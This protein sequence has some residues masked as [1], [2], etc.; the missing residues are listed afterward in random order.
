[1]S[2][3]TESSLM[4]ASSEHLVQAVGLAL[5]LGDLGLSV[6]GEVSKLADLM[7]RHEARA[8]EARLQQVAQPRRVGQIGLSARHLLDVA[9]VHQKRLELVLE[10]RPHR[11]PVDPGGLHRHLGHLVGGQP[12]AQRQERGGRRAKALLVLL[13]SAAATGRAHGGG[14][15]VL[16]HVEGRAAAHDRLHGL[17][18]GRGDP[19]TEP[20]R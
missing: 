4:P 18:L 17:L 8:Q 16:V 10:H 11:S 5:A 9:G 20:R 15:R 2:L 7:R 12:V 13:A 1:M 3:A 6:A 14:D 19:P